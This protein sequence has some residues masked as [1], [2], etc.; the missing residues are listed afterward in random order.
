MSERI[1]EAVTAHIT[2]ALMRGVVPWRKPW[3]GSHSMPFNA[4]SKKHY[5]G[6]N[7][8]LLALAHFTDPRWVTFNQARELGGT[9]LK[10]ERAMPVV[11]WKPWSTEGI[12][13]ETGEV[14]VW[15]VPLLKRFHVFNVEQCDGLELPTLST[16]AVNEHAR[17]ERAEAFLSQITDPPEVRQQG[18][19]AWYRPAEDLVQV[20]P[21]EWFETA[22]SFYGTLFHELGH[23]TGHEKRL[24]RPSV[25][26]EVQFGSGSYSR[27]E[28][29]AELTSA[30]CCASIGLDNSL[31]ENSASYIQSWLSAL[32]TDKRA[33]VVAASKAQKAAD[34]LQG[35]FSSDHPV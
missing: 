25:T 3:R 35:M 33:L 26:G 15:R 5:R 27:E 18:T 24:N 29:I 22:D 30:Y 2:N 14:Y 23:A 8:F 13:Q 9:V 12:D 16:T 17:I 34:Y 11:F 32:R 10:G 20:P 7:V 28:L 21:L 6:I 19:S 4:V 31:I 1:Y